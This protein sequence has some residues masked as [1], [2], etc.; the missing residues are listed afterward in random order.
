MH[1]DYFTCDICKKRIDTEKTDS[2]MGEL[3]LLV[4]KKMRQAGEKK[5]KPSA[6]L[7]E[8][9]KVADLPKTMEYVE[10]ISINLCEI[11]SKSVLEF[12]TNARKQKD[13]AKKGSN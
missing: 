10:R 5:E 9:T 7:F 3:K 6:P 1:I 4:T 8:T 2:I 12:I 13:K 11:H